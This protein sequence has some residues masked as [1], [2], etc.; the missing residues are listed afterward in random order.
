MTDILDELSQAGGD[1]YGEWDGA[2][3][4]VPMSDVP[5]IQA[6][7]LW[8]GVVP[9]RTVTVIAAPAGTSKG[10]A[11]ARIEAIT[12]TGEPFPGQKEGREP[13]QVVMVAPEDD[14]NEDMVYRL[15][16]AGANRKLIRNL[17][18]LPNGAPFR[19]PDNEGELRQAISDINDEGGPPVGLVT[20]DP[21]GAVCKASQLRSDPRAIIEPLQSVAADNGIALI[22]SVH[23]TKNPNVVAGGQ[24]LVDTARLVWMINV[25]K[26]NPNAR[27]MFVHKTNRKRGPAM[28][29][30]I[31]GEEE[32]ARVVFITNDSKVPGSRAAKLR[33]VTPATAAEEAKRWLEEH[34]EESEEKAS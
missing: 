21:L 27:V 14:P 24:A 29:Y 6:T 4:T 11:I 30:V 18:L 28:R 31:E 3:L 23:T 7:Y 10:L 17:T 32:D 5:E 33:L 13:M 25:A 15:N 26:D 19:L 22:A 16:A 8:P 1:D 9:N 12:S 34:K 20:I 2:S